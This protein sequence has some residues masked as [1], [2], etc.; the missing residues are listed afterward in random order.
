M[1]PLRIVVRTK[2]DWSRMD[3]ASFASQDDPTLPLRFIHQA[4]RRRVLDVWNQAFRIG[5]FHYR[6]EL[7]EIASRSHHDVPNVLI[8]E[9]LA[10][11]ESLLRS[12]GEEIIV[13]TDDDDF[14]RPA[15]SRVVEAFT[16]ETNVVIWPFLTMAFTPD[17]GRRKFD[18]FPFSILGPNNCAIRKSYLAR[19]QPNE[20][21][22]MLANHSKANN[23]IAEHLQIADDAKPILGL[24]ILNHPSVRVTSEVLSLYNAHVGSISFLL[25]DAL[26]APAPVAFL[27]NL[28]H[29]SAIELPPDAKPFAPYV[30][31]LEKLTSRLVAR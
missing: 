29:T 23:A 11:V 10:D 14:F 18:L 27:R 7:Q 1:L 15:L 4:N 6:A 9:G 21:K 30:R 26:K 5:F 17:T 25:Q 19:F 13:P 16:P 20:A 12:A 24:R 2:P 8:T 3:A 22:M 31:Q 28:D